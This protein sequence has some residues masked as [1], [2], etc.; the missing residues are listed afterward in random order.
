MKLTKK[1]Q[2]YCDFINLFSNLFAFMKIMKD[3]DG[4]Y[5]YE[6][7]VLSSLHVLNE[8]KMRP[9]NQNELYCTVKLHSYRFKRVLNKLIDLG[10]IQNSRDIKTGLRGTKT[11]Y[12]LTVTTKG[13][14]FLEWCSKEMNN[15]S[16]LHK[17]SGRK[18]PY[19]LS[20]M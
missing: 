6:L 14:M 5:I 3:K 4:I 17:P 12:R 9:M 18:L 1:E 2:S 20:N 11:A 7:M 16:S 19:R 15:L 10:Y 13:V 8:Q